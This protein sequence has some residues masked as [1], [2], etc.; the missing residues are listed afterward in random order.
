MA[1]GHARHGLTAPFLARTVGRASFLATVT[2]SAQMTPSASM[3]SAT[4]MNPAMFAPMT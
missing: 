2:G 3:A 4:W 1:M